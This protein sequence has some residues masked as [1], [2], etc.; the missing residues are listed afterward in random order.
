MVR[1]SS[2]QSPGQ[3]VFM[4]FF[5]LCLVYC[6]VILW[7][8]CLVPSALHDIF[9]TRVAKYSLFVLKV[10]LNT[11]QLTNYTWQSA[12][13]QCFAQLDTARVVLESIKTSDPPP[14][15][16]I[17][18]LTLEDLYPVVTEQQKVETLEKFSVS[19]YLTVTRTTTATTTTTNFS[20]HFRLIR[21]GHGCRGGL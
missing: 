5:F 15:K 11:S 7:C 9:D 18:L 20:F 2:L 21:L 3:R 17:G 1:G 4:I 12:L 6:F 14:E 13:W 10:L 16:E 19:Y 8:V